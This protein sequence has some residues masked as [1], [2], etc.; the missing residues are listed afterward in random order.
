M[1]CQDEKKKQKKEEEKQDYN[2][3]VDLDVINLLTSEK[4]VKKLNKL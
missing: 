3:Y 4:L 1:M 2:E